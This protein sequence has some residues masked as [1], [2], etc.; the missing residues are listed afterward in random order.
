M[1]I[2]PFAIFDICILAT[3]LFLLPAFA[4]VRTEKKIDYAGAALIILSAGL[5]FY[6]LSNLPRGGPGS[7]AVWLPVLAGLVALAV[8]ITVERAQKHPL[9][10]RSLLAA[11]NLVPICICTVIW[12]AGYQPLQVLMSLFLQNIGHVPAEQAGFVRIAEGVVSILAGLATPLVMKRVP[13]RYCL[14]LG[15]LGISLAALLMGH[16]PAD[17]PFALAVALFA[18]TAFPALLFNIG[19]LSE[20]LAHAAPDQ[21]GASAGFWA[22]S[23]LFA[24]PIGLAIALPSMQAPR[25]RMAGRHPAPTII[26]SPSR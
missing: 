11:P 24:S 7:I 12:G 10:S 5:L 4:T 16:L 2:A 9:M 21:K 1:A 26:S 20:G 18:L 8:L 3:I 14:V 19:S 23:A 17:N 6:G 25:R 13:P 15:G 22:M